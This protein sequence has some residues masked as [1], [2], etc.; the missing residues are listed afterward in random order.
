M[1]ILR[2]IGIIS[3]VLFTGYLIE[4][5]THT[6]IPGTILG[7]IIL[8]ILL[9]TGIIKIEMIEEISQFLLDH[10]T[11]LFLPAGV[12]LISQLGIIKVNW[13]PMFV[14]ILIS[15]TIAMIVTALT[16]QGLRKMNKGVK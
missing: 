5:M 11:F 4:K 2:Q 15:T 7:M 10:L 1:K 9:I 6:P 8:L 13:L 3:G 14:I 16:I 12:G